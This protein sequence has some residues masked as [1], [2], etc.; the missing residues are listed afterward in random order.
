MAKVQELRGTHDGDPR[1]LVHGHDFVGLLN[2]FV[3][4]VKGRRL[5]I[6]IAA[7]SLFACLERGR[8]EGSELVRELTRRFA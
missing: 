2:W 8:I 3:G 5:D 7:R 4:R 6:S 1:F